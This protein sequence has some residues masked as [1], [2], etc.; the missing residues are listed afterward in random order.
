MMRYM[1]GNLP[2]WRSSLKIWVGVVQRSNQIV[3]KLPGEKKKPNKLEG[4][5]RILYMKNGIIFSEI[6]E[7]KV[8]LITV[9]IDPHSRFNHK[10][11]WWGLMFW[12]GGGLRTSHFLICPRRGSLSPK[13]RPLPVLH[14]VAFAI[15]GSVQR[16]QRATIVSCQAPSLFCCSSEKFSSGRC[17][18]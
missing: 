2:N 8:N 18:T 13:L 12:H 17:F 6:V 15:L 11:L 9:V 10:L 4:I 14:G 7:R 1:E 16:D 5:I 3:M